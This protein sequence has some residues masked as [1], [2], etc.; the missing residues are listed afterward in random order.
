LTSEQV[1]DEDAGDR[2]ETSQADRRD[3]VST[4]DETT[5]DGD[6]VKSKLANR[7]LREKQATRKLQ[8]VGLVAGAV[9]IVGVVGFL[10]FGRG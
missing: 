7:E 8:I 1:T 6:Y 4:S 9:I 3:D 2:T 10:I 5:V